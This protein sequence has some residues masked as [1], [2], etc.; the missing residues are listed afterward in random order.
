[1]AASELDSVWNPKRTP[2][3]SHL[4]FLFAVTLVFG[5]S[6]IIIAYT[7]H[8]RSYGGASWM[9][10]APRDVPAERHEGGDAQLRED[11][12]RLT[13]AVN[14]Q[15]D[16][17]R[18]ELAELKGGSAGAG[19]ASP[20]GAS[21]F[22]SYDW[23]KPRRL[24][25]LFKD[26]PQH[27]QTP[28]WRSGER[29]LSCGDAA[30]D[31]AV[32]QGT[33]ILVRHISGAHLRPS[34]DPSSAVPLFE[35]ALQKK[36][37]CLSASLSLAILL[38]TGPPPG[39]GL[40]GDGGVLLRP[41]DVKPASGYHPG[42]KH[43]G[44]VSARD[45]ERALDLLNEDLFEN[46]KLHA[47]ALLWRGF[48]QELL[49]Q[50]NT[51]CHSYYRAYK[52]DPR[53]AMRYFGRLFKDFVHVHPRYFFRDQESA[54]GAVGWYGQHVYGA[55]LRRILFYAEFAEHFAGNERVTKGEAVEFVDKW[56]I[57]VNDL[58]PPYVLRTIQF[59]Y[60]TLIANGHLQ[61]Q[62]NQG[63]RYFK[64]RD[65]VHRYLGAVY[66]EFV[67]KITDYATKPTYG[68]M[69]A[70]IGGAELKPHRDRNQCEWTMTISTDVN[71]ASE[72][73]PLS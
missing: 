58:I 42:R 17:L 30:A 56:R 55:M 28:E 15:G 72:I 43:P 33:S 61:L 38:V 5:I 39:I 68:Y 57:V 2:N 51:S 40:A 18:R 66:N 26:Y 1:M 6:T 21:R 65:P 31:A 41:A 9:R 34:L 44:A 10:A 36:P 16:V 11:L 32:L 14:A 53:L 23:M 60:R 25:D 45:L 12:Q 69:G 19:D 63:M 8:R 29:R 73:C 49:D 3:S 54:N 50:T 4:R 59:G 67:S 64:H 22:Q 35:E 24:S 37:K 20:G 13:E 27:Q 48:A 46:T 70:Y 7:S 52:L 62:D 47:K 71:P